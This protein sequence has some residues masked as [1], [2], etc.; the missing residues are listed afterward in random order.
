M[1]VIAVF[2][3]AYALDWIIGDPDWM[4][5]P[6]RWMGRMTSVGGRLMRKLTRGRDSEF[7]FGLV[8]TLSVVGTFG[9]GSWLLLHWMYSRTQVLWFV[10]S[11]YFASSALATRSLLK[12]ASAVYRFLAAGDLGS[13]RRQV[14]RIV[15]RDTDELD[16]AEVVR[17]AIETL[18]ESAC[19]G[20]V[21]PMLFLALGG[22]PW[23]VAYKAANTMDSMIGHHDARYEYF[24]KAAARL[25]DLFNFVPAR[26]T[27]LFIVAAAW[28]LRMNSHEAWSVMLRDGSKHKSPNAG[29]PE[30][31]MAGA[32]SIRLGGTNYYDGE[33]HHGPYLGDPKRALDLRALQ[34]SLRVTTCVSLLMFVCGLL[35]CVA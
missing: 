15:G 22:V 13:A 14:G 3:A 21:A 29:R 28:T 18:A 2:V 8:L 32:L 25:D 11:L 1:R 34:D 17:A 35:I 33:A 27:A 30:A 24:G 16:P 31:A 10:T 26:L 12:E 6:V 20:I 23:A 4:P 5:H 7:A 9:L 19:D